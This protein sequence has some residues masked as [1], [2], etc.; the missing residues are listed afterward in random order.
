MPLASAGIQAA[1]DARWLWPRTAAGSLSGDLSK[2]FMLTIESV[3][4]SS[5]LAGVDALWPELE[6]AVSEADDRELQCTAAE[7]VG[8]I[9]RASHSLTPADQEQ[10]HAR[11]GPLVS[12]TL[13]SLSPNSVGAW[14]EMLRY[15]S[16]NRDPRRL[17][18]LT[19]VVLGLSDSIGDDS[20]GGALAL[21]SAPAECPDAVFAFRCAPLQQ[22]LFAFPETDMCWQ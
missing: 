21:V 14:A 6:K 10:L 16:A 17:N 9:V 4:R 15:V 20:G 13:A 22:R 5:G 3:V 2:N 18:W 1:C 8:G 7:M 12:S 19:G 11:L